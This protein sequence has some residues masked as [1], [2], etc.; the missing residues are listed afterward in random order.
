MSGRRLVADSGGTNVR[1]AIADAAGNIERLQTY[2]ATDFPQFIDA[3][4][5]YLK[6]LG[7]PPHLDA[8]V[9]AAAG[10]IDD[11]R[12][13]LTNNDWT[14]NRDEASA[15][16]SGAPVM[17]VNDL[18]AVAAALP[19]LAADDLDPVGVP[20][21]KQPKT[22]TMLAVNI[23][24]GFGAAS[25]L[26]RG[27]KWWTHP[28]EAGHMTLGTL[29]TGETDPWPEDAVIESLLSG[30]GVVDLYRRLAVTARKTTEPIKDASDVFARASSDAIA[31]RAVDIF[32]TMFGR[33][34]GD[35]VLATAAWGGVY[36]CGSVALGWSEIADPKKFRDEFT[37]KGAM[38]TRIQRV[39]TAAIRRE[40]VS[41]F[42][43]AKMVIDR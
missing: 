27:G 15:A 23:G 21:F 7:E 8:G 5:A 38:Q 19:H 41:L 29:T 36:L 25:A 3:L 20:A 34:V 24:T 33:V 17:L 4:R 43:L 31:A 14:I 30:Q 37:R 26:R 35:L 16:L 6:T 1:F 9:I 32:T 10:P 22:L 12:V 28:S 42:G 13:K 39:P 18:E 40:N 11:G 2:L